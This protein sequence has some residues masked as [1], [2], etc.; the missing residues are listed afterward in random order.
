M[1]AA[2]PHGQAANDAA[3]MRAGLPMPPEYP[4]SILI[5][6]AMT[7]HT[8]EVRNARPERGSHRIH[9]PL[10]DQTDRRMQTAAI[11]DR[12]RLREATRVQPGFPKRLVDIDVPKAGKNPLVKQQRLEHTRMAFHDLD[13]TRPIERRGEGFRPQDIQDRRRIVGI[14]P[15]TELPAVPKT[16]LPPIPKHQ[17]DPFVRITRCCRRLDAQVPR[18]P[19]MHKQ[20]AI[21]TQPDDNILR[22]SLHISDSLVGDRALKIDR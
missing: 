8:V 20:P 19:Q 9:A 10:K 15:A 6:P 22:P 18:H 7:G 5:A 13:Q 3:A 21:R 11:G 16:E 17:G 4:E 2:L 14:H 12:K 1:G